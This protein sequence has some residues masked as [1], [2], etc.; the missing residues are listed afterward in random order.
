ME[1]R[2]YAHDIVILR[3]DKRVQETKQVQEKILG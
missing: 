2:Y 3:T 1:G